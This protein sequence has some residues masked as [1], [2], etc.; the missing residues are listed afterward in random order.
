MFAWRYIYKIMFYIVY[1]YAI[2]MCINISIHRLCIHSTYIVLTIFW[3]CLGTIQAS[4]LT[5]SSAI[6]SLAS[7]IAFVTLHK[8]LESMAVV[9]TVAC[10]EFF[11]CYIISFSKLTI[12]SSSKLINMC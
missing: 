6:S 5:G 7:L 3:T 4:A 10:S 9:R 8:S 11:L 1:I 12:D 2:Y